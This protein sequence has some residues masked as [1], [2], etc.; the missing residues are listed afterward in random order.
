M[1]SSMPLT[2]CTPRS[3]AL[4]AHHNRRCSA[5]RSAYRSFPVIA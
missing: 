5:T 2:Q 3:G 4:A 1:P